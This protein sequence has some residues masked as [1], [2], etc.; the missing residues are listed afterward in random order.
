MI[1]AQSVSRQLQ[2]LPTDKL[3]E[4]RILGVQASLYVLQAEVLQFNTEYRL[5][6]RSTSPSWRNKG[7]QLLTQFLPK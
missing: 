7:S 3:G 6:M 5:N 2:M 1:L 4:N